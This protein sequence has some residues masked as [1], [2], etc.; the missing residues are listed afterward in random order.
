MFSW[1]NIDQ[2]SA[3]KELAEKIFRIFG[4]DYKDQIKVMIIVRIISC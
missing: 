3:R 1:E 4:S 2:S